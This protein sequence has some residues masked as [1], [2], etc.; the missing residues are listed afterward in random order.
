MDESHVFKESD[1]L[2]VTAYNKGDRFTGKAGAM[3][4]EEVRRANEGSANR[5]R[6]SIF[7]KV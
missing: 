2:P 6:K 3:S 4:D 5:I 1:N 7:K